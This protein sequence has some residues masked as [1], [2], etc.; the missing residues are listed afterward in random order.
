[1]QQSLLQKRTVTQASIDSKPTSKPKEK[2][3]IS[4]SSSDSFWSDDSEEKEVIKKH[5]SSTRGKIED[6]FKKEIET[7]TKKREVKFVEKS[8]QA[9]KPVTEIASKSSELNISV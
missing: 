9:A 6:F 2:K 3:R 4:E 8:N 7:P 1:M 5:V